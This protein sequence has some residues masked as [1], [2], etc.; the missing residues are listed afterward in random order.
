MAYIVFSHGLDNKPA[1]EY[2]WADVLYAS[3]DANLAAYESAVGDIETLG[4][5]DG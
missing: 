1:Q 2:L 4:N 3:P 5:S